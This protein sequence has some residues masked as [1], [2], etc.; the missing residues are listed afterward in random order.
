MGVAVNSLGGEML[1]CTAQDMAMAVSR[2]CLTG[3]CCVANM[4]VV[5]CANDAANC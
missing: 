2:K 4:G 1:T 5:M 3:V